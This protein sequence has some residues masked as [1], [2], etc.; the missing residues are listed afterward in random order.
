[1]STII[2]ASGAVRADGLIDT[3]TNL[4]GESQTAVNAVVTVGLLAFVA[5]ATFKGGFSLARL[6]MSALVAGFCAWLVL[7]QGIL[8][9]GDKVGDDVDASSS[10]THHVAVSVYDRH[11]V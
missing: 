6:L 3:I 11:L 4:A 9:V 5:I 2:L 1:M 7:A 8:K 10:T